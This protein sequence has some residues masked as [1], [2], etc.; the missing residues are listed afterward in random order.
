MPAHRQMQLF[1]IRWRRTQRLVPASVILS[2][3]AAKPQNARVNGVL[4]ANL[5]TYCPAGGS[6]PCNLI[7]F[8][9]TLVEVTTGGCMSWLKPLVRHQVLPTPNSGGADVYAAIL[10]DGEGRPTRQP[11]GNRLGTQC[12][13]RAESEDVTEPNLGCARNSV[14]RWSTG[15]WAAAALPKVNSD[16]SQL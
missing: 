15:G 4:V 5:L 13:R 2:G 9:G 12:R 14:R 11:G 3:C 1:V 7:C 16:G 10:Q 6:L 8:A